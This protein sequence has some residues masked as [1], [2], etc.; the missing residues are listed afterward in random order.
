LL[1]RTIHR[2]IAPVLKIAVQ[3][4]ANRRQFRYTNFGFHAIYFQICDL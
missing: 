3:S 1:K 4:T 2:R